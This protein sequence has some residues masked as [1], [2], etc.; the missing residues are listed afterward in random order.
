MS[1]FLSFNRERTLFFSFFSKGGF[2]KYIPLIKPFFGKFE[3][4]FHS[5]MLSKIRKQTCPGNTSLFPK[6]H[7]YLARVFMCGMVDLGLG[8]PCWEFGFNRPSGLDVEY[9][10]K[11]PIEWKVR[12]LP[13]IKNLTVGR[14][15]IGHSHSLLLLPWAF[16]TRFQEGVRCVEQNSTLL[17]VSPV[18]NLNNYECMLLPP[19]ICPQILFKLEL[20]LPLN[21]EYDW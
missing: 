6:G 4:L 13:S 12:A 21:W 17:Q 11:N 10:L 20:V 1:I 18:D 5:I 15:N 2:W 19:V 7:P 3:A 9:D 8:Y 16:P 14:L